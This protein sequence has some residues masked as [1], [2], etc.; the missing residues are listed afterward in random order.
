MPGTQR[1]RILLLTEPALSTALLGA[2]AAPLQGRSLAQLPADRRAAPGAEFHG[3]GRDILGRAGP[4]RR[5]RRGLLDGRGFRESGRDI[6]GRE[7]PWGKAERGGVFRKRPRVKWAERTS[8]L[9]RSFRGSRRDILGVRTQ[10]R[11]RGGASGAR[12]RGTSLV[13]WSLRCRWNIQGGRIFRS[14]RIL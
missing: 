7:E 1:H 9:G 13:R 14:G 2:G 8:L 10:P 4:L 12:C 3:S 5:S 11:G 6:L